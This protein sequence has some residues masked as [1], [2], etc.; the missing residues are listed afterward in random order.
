MKIR[1]ALFG[2]YVI[3]SAAGLAVLMRFVLA[4]VRPRYVSSIERTMQD[5]A[6]L[7]AASLGQQSEQ[8]WTP[9]FAALAAVDSGLA[10]RVEDAKGQVLFE[11]RSSNP[12]GT[13]EFEAKRFKSAKDR[14]SQFID[15]QPFWDEGELKVFA[16]VGGASEARGRVV[17]SRPLRSVNA[18]IWSERKKL[19]IGALIIAAV[20]VALGWWL[21]HKLTISLERLAAYAAAVRDGK[22]AKPPASRATE[23]AAVS[24]AMEGM[25]QALA[26]KAYVEF[27]TQNL[28]HEIKAP[29]SAIRAAT[30]LLSEEM[31]P[32]DRAKFLANLKGEAARLHEVVDRMLRLAALES[33][34]QLEHPEPFGI[35]DVVDEVVGA[36]MGDLEARRVR[37]LKEPGGSVEVLGERFLVHQ[38]LANLLHN[39]VSF[40]PEESE[41]VIGWKVSDGEVEIEVKDQGPGIPDYA[42]ARVFERFYSLPRPATGRKGTGLGLNFVREIAT[43]HQGTA[44]LGNRPEGGARAWMR[45]PRWK[46]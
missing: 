45:L 25:R 5:S 16:E 20:M 36:A 37:V 42:Q 43:L 39:A 38:A 4:E 3:A 7:L 34:M 33:R 40:A 32:E 19:T 28:A 17:L 26:G 11:S 23:I 31:P 9:T 14:I 15:S 1:T 10:L 46:R 6:E 35:A 30:E 21:A 27:Y 24:A 12:G 22:E 8:D 44:G 18:L 13:D 2:T 29:L 41:I